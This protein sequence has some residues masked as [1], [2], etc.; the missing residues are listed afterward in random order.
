[1]VNNTFSS[2]WD[3]VPSPGFRIIQDFC[4]LNLLGF[5]RDHH[6][7]WDKGYRDSINN[8][9]SLQVAFEAYAQGLELTDIIRFQQSSLQQLLDTTVRLEK[10]HR[11]KDGSHFNVGSRLKSPISFVERYGNAVDCL[12]QAGSGLVLNPAGFKNLP[13][14][15]DLEAWSAAR[16]RMS[17]DVE[18]PIIHTDWSMDIPERLITQFIPMAADATN[19]ERIKI[20]YFDRMM[21]EGDAMRSL[22]SHQMVSSALEADHDD[23]RLIWTQ[24]EMGSMYRQMNELEKSEDTLN[25]LA[26]TLRKQG[27][28]SEALVLRTKSHDAL[29]KA[30]GDLH[31]YTPWSGSDI[32]KCYRDEGRFED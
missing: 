31:P 24:N 32:A 21:V 30:L 7:R 16:R 27:R 15:K 9:A 13:A 23:S 12:V 25:T 4:L 20:S 5:G 18:Q 10:E 22:K 11:A 26:P 2:E 8:P 3:R 6:V 17:I 29:R 19:S 14:E 28:P 1:M